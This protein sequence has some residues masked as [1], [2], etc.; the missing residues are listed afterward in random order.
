MH[1]SYPPSPKLS[2]RSNDESSVEDYDDALLDVYDGEMEYSHEHSVQNFESVFHSMSN[3]QSRPSSVTTADWE[4]PESWMASNQNSESCPVSTPGSSSGA[5][6]LTGTSSQGVSP[7]INNNYEQA[8]PFS[9][10]EDADQSLSSISDVLQVEKDFMEYVMSFPL[11]VSNVPPQLLPAVPAVMPK[12]AQGESN[13]KVGLDH[14]DNLCKLMEQLSDLKEANIKLKRR[15]QYL[16]DIKTLH[17]IHKEMVG[18]RKLYSSGLSEDEVQQLKQKLDESVTREP[19]EDSQPDSIQLET[20]PSERMHGLYRSKT[21]NQIPASDYKYERG[22]KS[23]STTINKERR[24]RS[25]SV[26]HPGHPKAPKKRPSRW[27]KVK[28]VLGIEKTDEFST[29]GEGEKSED[30]ERNN[31][32]RMVKEKESLSRKGSDKSKSSLLTSRSYSNV[33]SS[34]S[35]SEAERQSA[36]S[37]VTGKYL[38]TSTEAYLTYLLRFFFL[39]HQKRG[40]KL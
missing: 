21:A 40:Q 2:N 12:K 3:E 38:I 22:H 33:L 19:S 30:H 36:A 13:P 24:E 10:P 4:E 25:K 29:G 31:Y 15:V 37:V 28:E 18:E 17:E 35:F 16:E 26:G 9:I 23:R 6:P 5:S 39:T 7:G 14:L 27:S 8:F 32:D 20:P 1:R 11:S 34:R